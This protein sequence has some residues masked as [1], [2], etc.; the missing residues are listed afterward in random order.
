M[1]TTKVLYSSIHF[2]SLH[3]LM[4]SNPLV[5]KNKNHQKSKL[6]HKVEI[7]SNWITC[8]LKLI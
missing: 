1:F 7:S 5:F 4:I 6:S 8:N 2:D 3:I